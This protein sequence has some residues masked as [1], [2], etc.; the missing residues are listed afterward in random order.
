M[1][2]YFCILESITQNKTTVEHCIHSVGKKKKKHEKL[3]TRIKFIINKLFEVFG[4]SHLTLFFVSAFFEVFMFLG[5]EKTKSNPLWFFSKKVPI[6]SH[7][8]SNLVLFFYVDFW[9]SLS[10]STDTLSFIHRKT[11]PVTQWCY[12]NA[13][14]WTTFAEKL[15][16]Y[17]QLTER[18][19]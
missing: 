10:F 9:Y 16:I 19:W 17:S 2:V 12:G 11:S 18:V 1:R 6:L 15:W 14:K 13:K 4:G 7:S 3:Y 5:N 8:E